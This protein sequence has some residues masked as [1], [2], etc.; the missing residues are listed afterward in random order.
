MIYMPKTLLSRDEIFR[1]SD[2]NKFDTTF[3]IETYLKSINGFEGDGKFLSVELGYEI[4][5]SVTFTIAKSVF[6]SITSLDRPTEGSLIYLPLDKK[7]YEIKFVDHQS[8]FYQLGKLN[9]YDLRCE[10]LEVNGQIFDTGIEEIDRLNDLY[11]LDGSED[12]TIVDWGDQ[13]I[14]FQEEGENFIDFTE[15]DPFSM[16]GEL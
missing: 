8:I 16:G 4:R 9:T 10:L 7:C 3:T 14:E 1:E 2:V 11:K 6:E 5:D 15:T 12:N 13:S